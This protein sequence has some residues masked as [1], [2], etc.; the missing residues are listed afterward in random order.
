M[1]RCFSID[2]DRDGSGHWGLPPDVAGEFALHDGAVFSPFA[3]EEAG[4]VG[5]GG[6]GFAFGR[7]EFEGD[8]ETAFA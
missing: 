8:G 2:H 1:S 4:P 7:G 5:G 3:E 6:E